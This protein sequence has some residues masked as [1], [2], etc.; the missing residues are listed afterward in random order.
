MILPLSNCCFF[1]RLTSNPTWFLYSIYPFTFIIQFHYIAD[2]FIELSIP[3][4]VFLLLFP[5]F[6]L[7][8][9]LF[10]SWIN[11]LPLLTPYPALVTLVAIWHF[12]SPFSD[13]K[14]SE[15]P[16]YFVFQL[17]FYSLS[18]GAQLHTVTKLAFILIAATHSH[19]YFSAI[20]SFTPLTSAERIQSLFFGK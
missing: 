17:S 8:F 6:F 3:Y 15:S 19:D 11:F 1:S 12:W 16:A 13:L 7:L 9:L 4:F 20:F 10:F 5:P 18:S 14:E 2:T